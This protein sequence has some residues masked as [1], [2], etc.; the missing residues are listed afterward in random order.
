MQGP[1][2]G[3]EQAHALGLTGEAS[4]GEEN[5]EVL[6]DKLKA[7]QQR[8][9]AVTKANHRLHC[10]SKS[11]SKTSRSREGILTC[12]LALMRQRVEY[13]VQLQAL[14]IRERP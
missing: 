14:P 4:S 9:T 3:R 1:V 5:L 11:K 7:S 13:S 2:P 6:V 8:A 10:I 12:C